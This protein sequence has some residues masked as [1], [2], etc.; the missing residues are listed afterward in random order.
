MKSDLFDDI[1]LY[2]VVHVPGIAT[3]LNHIDTRA[4]VSGYL[5]EDSGLKK[6]LSGADVVVVTAGI[7]RKPGMTRDGKQCIYIMHDQDGL[8]ISIT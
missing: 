6:A 5:P 2:D 4:R 7:A 1:A 3:D 8:L